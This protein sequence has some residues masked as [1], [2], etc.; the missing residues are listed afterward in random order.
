MSQIA[1]KLCCLAAIIFFA[2]A[3]G[4]TTAPAAVS[5]A[6]ISPYS[7]ALSVGSQNLMVE[8]ATDSQKMAQGL[9]GRSSMGENQGMLFD[10]GSLQS[11]QFWMKDM[12]FNLDF[13]WIAKNKVIG[14]TPD[15]PAPIENLKFDV[16]N[17]PRYSPP[18]PVDWVLEVN[19]GWSKANNVKVGDEVRLVN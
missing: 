11:P 7:R 19:A 17:L 9:S 5:P 16:E 4:Q 1:K 3:C 15:V 6:A 10:F 2:A 13:I 14:I 8:V 12:Q 18:S